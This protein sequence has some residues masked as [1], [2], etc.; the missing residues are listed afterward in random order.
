MN[1]EILKQNLRGNED[2]Q[3]KKI[4]DM[5]KRDV[6]SILISMFNLSVNI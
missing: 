6:T 4:I 5:N 1:Y 3:G 2:R